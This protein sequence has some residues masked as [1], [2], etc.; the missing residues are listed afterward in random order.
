MKFLLVAVLFLAFV[1]SSFAFK[2]AACGEQFANIG[3]GRGFFPSWSYDKNTNKC[4]PFIYG[5][6]G[7]NSNSFLS[8]DKCVDTCVE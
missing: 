3:V 7:G 1:A 8:E 4:L 5:G 2:N 6:V